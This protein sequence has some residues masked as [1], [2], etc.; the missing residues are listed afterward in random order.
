ME[1]KIVI[2]SLIV[3]VIISFSIYFFIEKDFEDVKNVKN[4]ENNYDVDLECE[5]ED[6]TYSDKDILIKGWLAQINDNNQ[7]INRSILLKD[8]DGNIISIKT[9]AENR[10]D[11][12]KKNTIETNYNKCGLI[13]RVG[14]DKLIKGVKYQ[15][16]FKVMSQDKR[17]KVIFIDEI[18]Q[19]S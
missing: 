15:I 12:E 1:N 7:Y 13:G 18:I 11:L 19:V 14:I 17:E 2:S 9:E 8:E 6:I 3:V 4:I 10:N 5:I 16:G